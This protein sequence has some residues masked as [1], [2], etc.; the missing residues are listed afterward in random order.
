MRKGVRR[1]YV[2]WYRS[3]QSPASLYFAFGRMMS[4]GK[5][6]WLFDPWGFLFN[7]VDGLLCGE[8]AWDRDV[9]P[10]Y[11]DALAS[12][13]DNLCKWLTPRLRPRRALLSALCGDN[14]CKLLSS[15]R[16]SALM[17]N[18]RN[19]PTYCRIR[20]TRRGMTVS[21]APC[22]P[23]GHPGEWRVVAEGPCRTW[24]ECD[25]LYMEARQATPE[26]DWF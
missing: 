15:D 1:D 9:S 8:Y 18:R 16:K 23:D 6:L 11:A 4:N 12:A 13:W 2:D 3:V 19:P 24:D 21:V 5:R 14:D 26:L 25:R 7:G 10:S 20:C 22:A 17:R